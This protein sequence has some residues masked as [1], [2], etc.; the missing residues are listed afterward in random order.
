MC[1][2][3]TS[4]GGV[5]QS[6]NFPGNYGNEDSGCAVTIVVP[7]GKK[8]Q[9]KFTTF[10]LESGKSLIEVSNASISNGWHFII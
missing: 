8:I 9:L 2:D 10:N 5:V 3:V 4:T 7:A 6:P 1:S